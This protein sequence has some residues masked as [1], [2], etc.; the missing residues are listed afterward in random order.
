MT[1]RTKREP[2]EQQEEENQWQADDKELDKQLGLDNEDGEEVKTL[3]PTDPLLV[4]LPDSDDDDMGDDRRMQ[5]SN[6]SFD[7]I[8]EFNTTTRP[9][10]PTIPPGHHE[11]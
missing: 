8:E 11:E 7:D 2:E 9:S 5:L 10:Y 3:S 1:R 6:N 4:P